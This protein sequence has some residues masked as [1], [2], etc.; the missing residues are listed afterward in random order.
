M[1]PRRSRPHSVTQPRDQRD[2]EDLAED[3]LE[4]D[5]RLRQPDRRRQ[6]A[7]AERRQRYEAEVD[8]LALYVR[9]LLREER[10]VVQRVRREV[11][12]REQEP[13]QDV[14]AQR[15]EHRLVGDPAVVQDAARG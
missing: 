3:R 9:A 10:T 7:E 13:E 5:E 6:V 8:V 11:D 1:S 15:A 2:E 12:E 4:R 14:D